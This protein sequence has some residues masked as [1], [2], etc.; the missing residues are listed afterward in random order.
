MNRKREAALIQAAKGGNTRAFAELYRAHVDKI[1]RYIYYRVESQETAE[2]LTGD[3]FLRMLE[4]LPTYED[5]SVPLL[6]W[7][8]RIAHA[9]VVDH[10]R[11]TGRTPPHENIESVDVSA[12]DDLDEG[13]IAESNSERLT[14]ALRTL[15]DGQRQVIIFRFV[16]GYNLETTARLL[17]KTVDSVKAMQYRALQA[18]A[19]VLGKRE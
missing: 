8:Y 17:G 6:V 10:Y 15:T 18:L 4:G 3:V 14:A 19:T 7:L 16:E 12:D 11:R 2:D 5:R 1:Y 9:R 13:L